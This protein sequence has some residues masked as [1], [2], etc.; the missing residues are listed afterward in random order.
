MTTPDLDK[1][2]EALYERD[3]NRMLSDK[4]SH[5]PF[6]ALPANVK[7]RY[8]ND[9]CR[10]LRAIREPSDEAK[11]C[12]AYTISDAIEDTDGRATSHKLFR[13]GWQAAIDCMTGE[14]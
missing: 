12:G 2:A 10:I 14:K 3:A 7:N 8:C 13:A 9:V 5:T 1:A 11:T 4:D 6:E